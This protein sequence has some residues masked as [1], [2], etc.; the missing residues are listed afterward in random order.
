M[1]AGALL[2]R[3]SA[4]R[5]PDQRVEPRAADAD[6][7]QHA[8]DEQVE[9]RSGG[10]HVV[11]AGHARERSR[12]H[13]AAGAVAV[14]DHAGEHRARC[15]TIRLAMAMRRRERLAADAQLLGHRRHV[16]SHHL[17]NAHGDA[18]DQPCR[19]H[20]DPQGPSERREL[21]AQLS[22]WGGTSL[23]ERPRTLHAHAGATERIFLTLQMSLIHGSEPVRVA[24]RRE[25]RML[26][27]AST[28]LR[29]AAREL[30]VA[31]MQDSTSYR[32]IHSSCHCGNIRVAF[33]WP[34]PGPTIPVRACG[35]GLCTKHRAV[36]TSHPG[37]RFRLRDRRRLARVAISV[38]HEDRGFSR[39]PD[40]RR[41]P[42]RHMHDRG[43]ALCR[44]QR[45]RLRGRR[46]LAARRSPHEL[47]RRDD[48]ESAG[49]TSAQ[50]DAGGGR[51]RGDRLKDQG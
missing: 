36:W 4:A 10:P 15:P 35:C 31:G 45:Q 51:E 20:D 38:R 27:S 12:H 1:R 41:D 6:A 21:A 18:D 23:F 48:G 39:L 13:D 25:P 46:P 42:D 9:A 33:D 24:Y 32:R 47:R 49:T 50:L 34:D 26:F 2:R 43:E 5:G 14:G 44:G 30:R 16:E 19:Q 17:A 11:D 7:H 8:A 3:R 28:Q 37:G 40:M 22:A 29:C